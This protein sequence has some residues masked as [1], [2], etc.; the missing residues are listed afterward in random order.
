MT[1]RVYR[2]DDASA[3][4]LTGQLGSLTTLLNA[5][6]VTGY[7]A[8]AAAGWSSPY[9]GTNKR[10]F[11]NG[12]GST[13]LYLRVLH[14]ATTSGD[15]ARVVGYESMSGVDN[16]SKPFPTA[17]QM[18]GGGYICTSVSA[19]NTQRPWIIIADEKRFYLWVGHN[20][21]TAQGLDSAS[22]QLLYFFGDILSRKAGDAYRFAVIANQSTSYYSSQFAQNVSGYSS[23]SDGH[24]L[25]RSHSQTGT[26]VQAGKQGDLSEASSAFGTDGPAF[27][28]ELT[29]GLSLAKIRMHEPGVSRGVL[30][31]CYAVLHNLPGNCGDTFS[32]VGALVGKTFLLL[33]TSAGSTRA[34]VALETS[35]TWE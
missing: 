28:D 10:V 16:G 11:R 23:F 35:N 32:G 5:C 21:T 17:A 18:A 27:P 6:L 33:D 4:T 8:K 25:A 13:Q 19:D 15:N 29:G 3:P 30:P 31:G 9:S 2:W 34:R 20:M 12:A 14:D 1:V 22:M 26:S 24:Y 7:G